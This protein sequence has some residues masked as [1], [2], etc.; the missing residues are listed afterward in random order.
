[1]M[2]KIDGHKYNFKLT[3]GMYEELLR[4]SERHGIPTARICREMLS[5][6]IDAYVSYNSAGVLH[7]Q[8]IMENSKRA[9]Q[10]AASK[11]R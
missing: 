8:E 11:R 4:L 6:G 2:K 1:M 7:F 3:Q 5:L 10:K 9:I